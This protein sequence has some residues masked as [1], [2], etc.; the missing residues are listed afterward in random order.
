MIFQVILPRCVH[1]LFTS[2]L[3]L[4]FIL[5]CYLAVSKA[6]ILLCGCHLLQGY[7]G[8]GKLI[9]FLGGISLVQ[10]KYFLW[11]ILFFICVIIAAVVQP[12]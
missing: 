3:S 2:R 5:A 8:I 11:G 12:D 9:V 10:R 4:R 7:S 6:P 1:I